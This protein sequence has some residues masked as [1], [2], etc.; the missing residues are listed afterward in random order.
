MNEIISVVILLGL[1][2]TLSVGVVYAVSNWMRLPKVYLERE[3]MPEVN[4][5]QMGYYV[6][7][8]ITNIAESP[9]IVFVE[10]IKTQ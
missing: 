6:F 8:N 9:C 2:I 4:F 1:T 3:E 5:T 10:D 7:V